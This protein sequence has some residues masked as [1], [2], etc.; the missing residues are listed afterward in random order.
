M[1]N[2]YC[3]G[4]FCSLY[5][6]FISVRSNSLSGY[7]ML[8]A[9][10]L[11]TCCGLLCLSCFLHTYCRF[12]CLYCSLLLVALALMPRVLSAAGSNLTHLL[13][14]FCLLYF[15]SARC[16]RT[17]SQSVVGCR[18]ESPTLAVAFC[19]LYFSSARCARTHFQSHIH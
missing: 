12:R 15:S 14:A 19:L 9:R 11:F 18:H 2:A 1:P 3:S 16:A 13:L 7:C 4:V 10:V 6:R 5:F 8:Q 17:H